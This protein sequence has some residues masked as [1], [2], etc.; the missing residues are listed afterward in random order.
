VK[1]KANVGWLR[2]QVISRYKFI[3]ILLLLAILLQCVLSMRMKSAT[4]DEP[5]HLIG[6][7]Y[8]LK[9]GDFSVNW[10]NPVFINIISAAPLLFLKLPC[11]S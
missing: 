8:Y 6:G 7:Y 1:L 4:F 9:M 2:Q 11:F 10:Q 5:S 3:V